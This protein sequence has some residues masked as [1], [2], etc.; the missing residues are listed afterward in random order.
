VYGSSVNCRSTASPEAKRA[1]LDM[2]PQVQR[3]WAAQ[4]AETLMEEQDIPGLPSFNKWREEKV[5]RD[6]DVRGA[7]GFTKLDIPDMALR[8]M[9]EMKQRPAWQKYADTFTRRLISA[10]GHVGAAALGLAAMALQ[11]TSAGADLAESA[12]AW[13]RSNN[14]ISGSLDLKG[15]LDSWGLQATAILADAIPQIG[16]SVLGGGALKGL[17]LGKWLSTAAIGGMQSPR[18]RGQ[19]ATIDNLRISSCSQCY[20]SK[21]AA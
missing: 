1:A 11:N 15:G 3:Q 2:Q 6:Q 21:V 20:F 8:Y 7:T 16:S 5:R 17:Q 4:M 12:A 14:T 13:T 10:G 9:E 19:G 18:K